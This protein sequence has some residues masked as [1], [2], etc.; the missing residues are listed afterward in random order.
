[1]HTEV[2]KRAPSDRAA[3]RR[4]LR[5]PGGRRSSGVGFRGFLVRVALLYV[6]IAYFVACP[7]D[8]KREY[9]ICRSIDSVGAHVRQFE[10]HVRPYVE[11]AQRKLQPYVAEV[12]HRAQPY[13]DTVKPYY[14]RADRL[15]RPRL[16]TA[17][18]RYHSTVYPALAGAVHRSQELT[19]PLTL[20]VKKQ[21]TKTLAPSVE[22]YTLALE[23]WY[24]VQLEPHVSRV[25]SQ[26]R[27]L[28]THAQRTVA[29]VW[30]HGVPAAQHHW[31]THL[32]PFSRSAYGTSRRT[33]VS[34][35]HPRAVTVWRA[36]HG[37][38]RSRV[39][40]ALQ[41]FWSKFIAPQL[42][43]IQERVFEYKA[44]RAKQE[45]IER[46]DKVGDD[47]AKA[48]GDDDI[49][50]AFSHVLAP[51]LHLLTRPPRPARRLHQRPPQGRCVRLCIRRPRACHPRRGSRPPSRLLV[52][53]PSPAPLGRGR[54]GP[55]RREARR[56]RGPPVRV[57]DRDRVAGPGRA[58]PPRCAPGRHPRRCRGR[59]PQ[60]VRRGGR[61]PR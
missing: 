42:D 35:V 49:E 29:P 43:K 59:H 11:T 31:R 38:Y 37:V 6:A 5:S 48:H 40:P 10:P 14:D 16:A 56:P 17:S 58:P 1:M 45:A 3:A 61:G 41:R 13:V 47:I 21:Y 8:P 53:G 60:A 26:A 9:A 20:K 2:D 34:H 52:V 32:V 25:S 28:A 22:W 24:A 30:K 57:R 27:T 4:A 39:L 7:H 18:A 55:A 33:Y 15:V 44:K 46:V 23:R 54:R 19:R 51:S 50:G 36:S 12:Q